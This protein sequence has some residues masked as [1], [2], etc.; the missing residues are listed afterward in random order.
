MKKDDQGFT[1]EQYLSDL[2]FREVYNHNSGIYK[3]ILEAIKDTPA[4]SQQLQETLYGIIRSG[5]NISHINEYTSYLDFG[6]SRR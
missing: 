6:H 2:L 3:Q 4:N 1:V 5:A